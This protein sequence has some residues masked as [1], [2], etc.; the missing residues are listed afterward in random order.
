MKDY[1][2]LL[3]LIFSKE[4]VEKGKKIIDDIKHLQALSQQR[5]KLKIQLEEVE[6]I[7]RHLDKAGVCNVEDIRLEDKDV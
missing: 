4:N 5:D 2:N 7:A 6:R 3:K 1:E